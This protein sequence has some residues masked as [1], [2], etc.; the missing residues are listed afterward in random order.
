MELFTTA[1]AAAYLRLK[2]RKIYEMV[3]EG[4]V[5]CTKVTGRWLFPKAELDH[6][7][8]A[9]VARPVGMARPEVAPIIGGSHDPLLEWALRESNSGLATLA[10]G[11]EAGFERFVAG[12]AMAAAIHLHA[13]DDPQADANVSV[14]KA[15]GD[16]QDAVL[17]AFCRREQ[18]FLLA[19]GNPLKIGAVDDVIAK[20]ARI[21]LRPRGAGAQL[22]LL[23]LLQRAKAS[24]DQLTIASPACPTGPDIAQAIRAGRADTGIATR[25]VA[26]AAGLDF[27]PILWEPF[28]LL[29]RQRDYFRPPLQALIR[30]LRSDELATRAREMGGYDL[31]EAGAVRFSG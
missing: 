26:N 1:E 21:A 17:I 27:V 14:V 31:N 12:D 6:W 30:F 16:L 15:R 29:M 9:S 28:D 11:S 10:V 24:L 23:S 7:L 5:P 20:R 18:G 2:E 8:A 25:A 3:A 19:P 4:T 13:L 22:L